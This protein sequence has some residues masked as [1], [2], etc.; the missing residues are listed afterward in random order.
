MVSL[1]RGPWLGKLLLYLDSPG[2]TDCIHQKKKKKMATK[3]TGNKATVLPHRAN[4]RRTAAR[5]LSQKSPQG[6]F[7]TWPTALKLPSSAPRRIW[8]PRESLQKGGL[9]RELTARPPRMS[10]SLYLLHPVPN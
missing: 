3:P 6:P 5:L 9:A 7:S 10:R 8:S 2:A 4:P 1:L